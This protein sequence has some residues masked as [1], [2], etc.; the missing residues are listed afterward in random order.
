MTRQFGNMKKVTL[1]PITRRTLDETHCR[2]LYYAAIDTFYSIA[3]N[4]RFE[5][6]PSGN[7]NIFLKPELRYLT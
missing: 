3:V 7:A 2:P 6:L 1:E 4:R 5:S